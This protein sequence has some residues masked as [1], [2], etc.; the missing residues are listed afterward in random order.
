MINIIRGSS[1]K[2][3]ACQSLVDFFEKFNSE[4][5]G[6]LYLGYPIIGS[7]EGP[8]NIDAMLVSP[9]FG[10]IIFDL[11]EG[12]SYEDRSD[13]RDDLYMKT[14]SKLADYK[15]LTVRR[16]LKVMI[17]VVTY[18]SGWRNSPE[19]EE[20]I[21]QHDELKSYL[22]TIKWNES[23]YYSSLLQAI[24][25]VTNIK[26]TPK[27][28]NVKRENSKGAI[29]KSLEDSIANLDNQQSAA[30]I[31]TSDSVQRIR[32]LAGSG[33]TIVLALKV[34]YLHSKNPDWDIAVTFQT[35]ALK[36]Q[37]EDLISR[38]TFEHK[39][40][41]PDWTKIKILQ[42]W[43]SPSNNGIYYEVCKTHGIEY[44][45]FNNAKHYLGGGFDTVCKRALSQISTFVPLYDVILI[46]EAQDFSSDFLKMCYGILRHPKRLIF[47]YDELQTLS[48]NSMPPVEEIFGLNEQGQPLVELRNERNK[49]KQDIILKVCYRNSRP[50]LAT[51]HALGFGVYREEGLVQLFG[52]KSLWMDVGYVVE[53]GAL[54]DGQMVK[55]GRNSE[56]SPDFLENHSGIDD[57]IQFKSFNNELSQE[58]WLVSEIIKNIQEDELRPQDIM[59]IHTDPVSTQNAMGNIRKKLFENGVNSHLA[60]AANP[61]MFVE[62]DSVTF[63]GIY[64]A[65]GNE[66]GMVYVINAQNCHSGL[67]L[68]KKRNILFTAITRSKGWVRISGFGDG[69]EALSKEYEKAK[70]NNFLLEFKYPTEEQ[71]KKMNIIHRD[72][73]KDT[74]KFIESSIENLTE[75][76]KAIKR[77]EMY[78]EDLP[79]ELREALRGIFDE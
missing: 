45:D 11:V 20:V 78:L 54:N 22:S 6:I 39:R 25:A 60:G 47:A 27:R 57:L 5:T 55:L 34:A 73:T 46:D 32:G 72:I 7:V 79:D 66:A 26:N 65:K 8:F 75:V 9:D 16:E 68:S 2:H 56:S 17:N 50:L 30:V 23:G 52:D 21:T 31:E 41:K 44:F 36:K 48:R 14:Q 1:D 69:M 49:P 59:V 58:D 77:K 3:V 28:D 70:V 67:E 18:A 4:Y 10:V 42:A 38:F 29:L 63:T 13:I 40:D 19:T 76:I 33:K 37:F 24:Q 15:T 74:R 61:D 51:A 43:G 62:E 64:R 35:R 53:E 71:R 12:I